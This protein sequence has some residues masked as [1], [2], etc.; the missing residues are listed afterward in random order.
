MYYI[1]DGQL[2]VVDFVARKAP[3]KYE[4]LYYARFPTATF[5]GKHLILSWHDGNYNAEVIQLPGSWFDF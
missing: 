4:A 3:V 5:D 2:E 1:E